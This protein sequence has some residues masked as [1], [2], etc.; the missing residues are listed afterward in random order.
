MEQVQRINNVKVNGQHVLYE[1]LCLSILMLSFFTIHIGLTPLCI[2]HYI[3]QDAKK[4]MQSVKVLFRH[5]LLSDLT[6]GME[7]SH[8][9][10]GGAAAKTNN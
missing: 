7:G 8:C 1:Y 4:K 5:I 2:S 10:L 6:S 3:L 9:V